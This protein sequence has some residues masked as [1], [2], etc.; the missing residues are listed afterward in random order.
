MSKH[1]VLARIALVV[2]LAGAGAAAQAQGL[3]RTL[4][5]LG[6]GE[7]YSSPY[8]RAIDTVAPFAGAAGLD[9]RLAPACARYA[10]K[11]L[12]VSRTKRRVVHE[13]E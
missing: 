3:A 4:A 6:I 1:S 2:V 12:S 10:Q 7:V 13:A 5:R 11:L 9:V 8:R